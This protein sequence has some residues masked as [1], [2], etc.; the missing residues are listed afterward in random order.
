HSSCYDLCAHPRNLTDEMLEALAE[1]GGIVGVHPL[2]AFITDEGRQATFDELLDHLEHMVEIMGEDHVAIG[3]DLMENDPE[4]EYGLLWRDARLPE[5]QFVYP[6]E[7]DS[8][9]KFPNLTAGMVARGFP[10]EVIVKI[11]GANALSYFERV[12]QRPTRPIESNNWSP[13]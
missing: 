10:D 1:S 6:S 3:P 11:L 7:F 13:W 2:S 5:Y 8:L 12:W 9:S 4:A